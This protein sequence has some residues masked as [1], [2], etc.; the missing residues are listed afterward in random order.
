MMNMGGYLCD[1]TSCN[2]CAKSHCGPSGGCIEGGCVCTKY[3]PGKQ[4]SQFC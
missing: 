3:I 4:Y 1:R 2:H